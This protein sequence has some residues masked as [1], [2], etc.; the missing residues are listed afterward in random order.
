MFAVFPCAI[1]FLRT[2]AL[3]VLVVPLGIRVQNS[4]CVCLPLAPFYLIPAVFSTKPPNM[5]TQTD[6]QTVTLIKTLYPNPFFVCLL[7]V[8][9]LRERIGVALSAQTPFPL[10]SFQRCCW[11]RAKP[12]YEW[13]LLHS[14]LPDIW[15]PD[16]AA[17][18]WCHTKLF[19]GLL[20]VVCV[21]IL[22]LFVCLLTT[23]GESRQLCATGAHECG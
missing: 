17:R 2:K 14:L 22:F 8:P 16:R 4:V 15:T 19:Q 20:C 13:H 6:T 1:K 11:S 23:Y 3:L 21:L 18:R 9:T 12:H 5:D 7:R 10:T